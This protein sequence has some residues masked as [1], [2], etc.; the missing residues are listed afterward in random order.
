MEEKLTFELT[1]STENAKRVYIYKEDCKYIDSIASRTNLN[2]AEIIRRI[3]E[4]SKDKT[5]FVE[6]RITTKPKRS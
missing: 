5:I 2:K 6:P 1:A 3:I 4:F